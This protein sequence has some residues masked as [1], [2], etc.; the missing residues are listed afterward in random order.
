MDI[1]NLVLLQLATIVGEFTP[2]SMPPD[3]DDTTLLVNFHLDSVAFT[4]LLARLEEQIGFIPLGILRGTSFPE[5]VGEL[6]AAY[7]NGAE[8]M[9]E[10][11][12]GV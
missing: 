2:Y 5:T 3:V 8:E 11:F 7:E 4:S 9:V 6:V 12:Q 10:I 1:R